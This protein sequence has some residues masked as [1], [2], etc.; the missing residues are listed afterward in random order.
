MTSSS[1]AREPTVGDAVYLVAKLEVGWSLVIIAVCSYHS[2]LVKATH[3]A[4]SEPSTTRSRTLQKKK[5]P[6]NSA[7][8]IVAGGGGGG[9]GGVKK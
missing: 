3:R 2:I 9:G 5:K 4:N 1:Q 7:S 8:K 6:Q